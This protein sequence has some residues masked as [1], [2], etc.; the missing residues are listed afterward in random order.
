M[1]G[2]KINKNFWQHFLLTG[3]RIWFI[4]LLSK[5]SLNERGDQYARRPVWRPGRRLEQGYRRRPGQ[6]N[7][8]GQGRRH[9]RAGHDARPGRPGSRKCGCE[10]FFGKLRLPPVRHAGTASAG[11]SLHRCQLSPLRNEND[12]GVKA[13]VTIF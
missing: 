9:R 1:R 11:K 8:R 13:A 3:R 7:L 10:F 4:V 6:R 2:I 12:Q 5:C